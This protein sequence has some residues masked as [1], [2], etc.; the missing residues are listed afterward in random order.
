LGYLEAIPFIDLVS[1]KSGFGVVNNSTHTPASAARVNNFKDA[2]LKAANDYLNDALYFL[3]NNAENYAAWNKSCLNEGSII[4]SISDWHDELGDNYNRVL[5]VNT[6]K[7]IKKWEQIW[8]R[9]QLSPEF[10]ASIAGTDDINVLLTIKKALAYKAIAEFNEKNERQATNE[11]TA[12][13]YL[14]EAI[15]YLISALALSV[16]NETTFEYPIY[17]TYGYTEPFAND[18]ETYGFIKLG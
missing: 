12:H 15:S 11:A 13:A 16:E 17:K 18:L 6:I 1:T 4:A 8:L 2:C 3:E 7:S 14:N 9:K 5:F 10:V